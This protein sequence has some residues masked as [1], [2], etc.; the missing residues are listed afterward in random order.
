MPKSDIPFAGDFSPNEVDLATLLH[1]AQS[2]AGDRR[3]FN[4][5]IKETY[6]EARAIPDSQKNTLAYNVSLGMEKYGLI[7]KDAR[8]TALGSELLSLEKDL[9]A[10][11]RRFARHILL[12]LQGA[13]ML[14]CIRDMHS[15]GAPFTLNSLR[16]ALAERGIHTP[17]ANKHMSLMLLWLGKAGLFRSRGVVDERV[18]AELLGISESEIQALS[19]LPREQRAVLQMVASIG[20]EIDSSRLRKRTQDAYGVR[21]DEKQ[22]PKILAPLVKLG[23]IEFSKR[24]AKSGIV[25]G[26]ERLESDVVIPLIE[27]LGGRLDPRVRSLIRLPLKDIVANLDSASGYEKGLALEALGFKM[28]RIVGLNYRDTRYRP[29]A[30]GGRFEVDLIFDSQVLAY[31]RWQVQC[32]NTSA[33]ALDDVAKEVGLTYYLLSNVI[34]ILTR[35][36]VGSEARSYAVDVMRKTNLA[37]ILIEAEDVAKIVDDPLYIFDV[38]AREAASALRLK[39]LKSEEV[40]VRPEGA[41]SSTK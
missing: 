28:L 41:D 33:V 11:F 14:E 34:V 13:T 8:L 9:P 16:E 25:R 5:S 17:P 39:P 6:Y 37:I 23:Y 27:Q 36:K 15:A 10:L 19:N 29:T 7:E 18:Y 35:G 12:E 30:G 20:E 21:L 4:A 40:S 26:T 1:V 31:S 22:F 24:R 3:A 2:R 32:K 38:L